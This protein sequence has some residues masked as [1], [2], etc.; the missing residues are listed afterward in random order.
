MERVPDKAQVKTRIAQDGVERKVVGGH[1]WVV[2]SEVADTKGRAYSRVHFK[3]R[4]QSLKAPRGPKKRNGG[5]LLFYLSPELLITMSASVN[6]PRQVCSLAVVLKVRDCD[7]PV[8]FGKSQKKPADP[9]PFVGPSK[10]SSKKG[11]YLPEVG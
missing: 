10:L 9:R 8:Q 3:K 1:G 4:E 11:V 5:K 7:T 6:Y 2:A